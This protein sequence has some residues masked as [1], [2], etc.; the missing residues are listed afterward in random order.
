LKHDVTKLPDA[1]P[2]TVEEYL[3]THGVATFRGIRKV[4]PERH[5]LRVFRE[6]LMLVLKRQATLEFVVGAWYCRWLEQR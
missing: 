3:K 5:W 1:M 6:V 2:L 4:F